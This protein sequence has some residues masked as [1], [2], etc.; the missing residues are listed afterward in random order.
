MK[1]KLKTSKLRV[2]VF[3]N[4]ENKIDKKR[5]Y[6]NSMIVPQKSFSFPP[7]SNLLIFALQ[8]LS[9]SKFIENKNS[10]LKTKTKS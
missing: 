6:K 10:K 2:Q 1:L 5:E 7:N 4:Y 3:K 8:I 9:P